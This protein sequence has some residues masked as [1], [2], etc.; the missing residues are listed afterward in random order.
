[1]CSLGSKT[2]I[3]YFWNSYS[4]LAIKNYTK[5]LQPGFPHPVRLSSPDFRNENENKSKRPLLTFVFVLLIF[6]M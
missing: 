5:G 3:L 6:Q 4:K 2:Q 1:M